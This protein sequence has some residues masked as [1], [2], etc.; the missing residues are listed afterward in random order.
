MNRTNFHLFFSLLC[1]SIIVEAQDLNI[2]E[3]LKNRGPEIKRFKLLFEFDNKTNL[4]RPLTFRGFK[5]G[6]KYNEVH[7]FGLGIFNNNLF[8]D[9]SILFL[10]KK[11]VFLDKRSIVNY[12]TFFYQYAIIHNSKWEVSIPIHLG[13]GKADH[14]L[15]EHRNRSNESNKNSK[16][17]NDVVSREVFNYQKNF[18]VWEL[19]L[20]GQYIF[21]EWLGIGAGL[22][23]RHLLSG[24]NHSEKLIQS[25]TYS[26]KLKI[27]FGK[28]IKSVHKHMSYEEAY[29]R[30]QN[31]VHNRYWKHTK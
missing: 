3:G 19:G 6:L 21:H 26:I 11:N 13:F 30:S 9:T 23:F 27:F 20:D 31:P 29:L 14:K 12:T 17:L 2:N 7:E 5:L 18:T 28:I 15:V 24:D 4:G 1:L 10:E 25:G 8:Y 22:G 16:I